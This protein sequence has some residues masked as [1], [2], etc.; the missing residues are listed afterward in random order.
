MLQGAFDHEKSFSH[1][2]KAWKALFLW[3]F[4]VL[5]FEIW[6]FFKNRQSQVWPVLSYVKKCA[7]FESEVRLA[8]NLLKWSVLLLVPWEGS[9]TKYM[10]SGPTFYIFIVLSPRICFCFANPIF[11]SGICRI[12]RD[13]AFGSVKTRFKAFWDLI[14]KNCIRPWIRKLHF[15]WTFAPGWRLSYEA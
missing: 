13:L 15:S 3:V 14:L 2:P 5:S 12:F 4:K 10:I 1:T 11:V 7:D 9:K 8:W 6:H